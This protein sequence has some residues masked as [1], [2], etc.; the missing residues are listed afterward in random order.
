[1]RTEYKTGNKAMKVRTVGAD[2]WSLSPKPQGLQRQGRHE[3]Q[4]AAG[5]DQGRRQRDEQRP[6]HRPTQHGSPRVKEDASG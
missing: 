2:D 1:M 3:E 5:D 4:Q 6:A